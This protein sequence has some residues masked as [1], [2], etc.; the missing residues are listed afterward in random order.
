MTRSAPV[1]AILAFGALA[2][3]GCAD[4]PASAAKLDAT[5]AA[6]AD[7]AA[8]IAKDPATDIESGVRQAQ[9]LRLAG[10]YDGAV[11]ILSQLMMVA[12]DDPRVVKAALTGLFSTERNRE[13][14]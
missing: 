14:A 5:Q 1:F 9:L 7:T 3:A 13:A 10:N 4:A 2:L 6:E 8:A 12:A 11:H